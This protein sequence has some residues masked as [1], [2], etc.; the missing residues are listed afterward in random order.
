MSVLDSLHGKGYLYCISSV[1]NWSVT[2]KYLKYL[3]KIIYDTLHIWILPKNSCDAID[4]TGNSD[5]ILMHSMLAQILS[6]AENL[7]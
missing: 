7:Q 2:F 3:F 4:K 5:V 1:T 6:S